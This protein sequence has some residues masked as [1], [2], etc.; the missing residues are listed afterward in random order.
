MRPY[1]VAQGIVDPG[2]PSPEFP[3]NSW[4]GEYGQYQK[5]TP[6]KISLILKHHDTP[7]SHIAHRLGDMDHF[8]LFPNTVLTLY[9]VGKSTGC[10][11]YPDD[12]FGAPSGANRGNEALWIHGQSASSARA[13]CSRSMDHTSIPSCV[14]NDLLPP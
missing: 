5:F 3:N 2:L 14:R 13:R 8:N 6:F 4:S 1:P 7:E 12:I 11:T 10:I 9:R